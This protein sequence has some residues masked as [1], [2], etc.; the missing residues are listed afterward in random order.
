M[1]N[2][3]CFLITQVPDLF[4]QFDAIL[5]FNKMPFGMSPQ[6]RN[7]LE[8]YGDDGL[9][10]LVEERYE[11][12]DYECVKN[13][14]LRV[15]FFVRNNYADFYDP[16]KNCLRICGTGSIFA[17]LFGNTAALAFYQVFT[18]RRTTSGRDMKNR[19]PLP[20]RRTVLKRGWV[21]AFG[22]LWLP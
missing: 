9:R 3:N 16:E 1:C 2:K 7:S 4:Y 6:E 17:R 19:L 18:Q 22:L 8:T 5:N 13:E 10:R 14:A 15:R 11:W 21:W 20:S 12:M